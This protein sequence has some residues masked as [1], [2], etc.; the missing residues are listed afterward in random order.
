LSGYLYNKW[1]DIHREMNSR[2]KDS[3]T[4]EHIGRLSSLSLI[5]VEHQMVSG[6]TQA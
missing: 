4:D 2:G 1:K 5:G 3:G 6:M